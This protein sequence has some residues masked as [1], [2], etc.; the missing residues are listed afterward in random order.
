S[1]KE[2]GVVEQEGRYYSERSDASRTRFLQRVLAKFGV[3]ALVR[4]SSSATCRSNSKHK[5]KTAIMFRL[6]ETPRRNLLDFARCHGKDNGFD[7]L[8]GNIWLSDECRR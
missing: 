2:S 7:C 3:E 1:T 4:R 8:P 6:I 5:L